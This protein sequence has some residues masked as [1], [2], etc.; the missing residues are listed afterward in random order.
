MSDILI[1]T[2]VCFGAPLLLCLLASGGWRSPRSSLLALA[3]YVVVTINIVVVGLAPSLAPPNPITAGLEWNW[4]GKAAAILASAAMFLL[5]PRGLKAE[6]GVTAAPRPPEWKSVFAVSSGLL[7]FFWSVALLQR[8]G[9]GWAGMAETVVFQGT[10]PGLDEELALRGVTLALLVGAFGKPWRVAGVS[11]GWGAL[12]L[13][14]FFGLVHGYTSIETGLNW[15]TI[16][17]TGVAGSGLLWL[18]ERT[19]SIW[20]PVIVHNLMN[21]GS[22]L[23]SHYQ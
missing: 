10:M 7:A 3:A 2:A 6:S 13:V 12:P 11:I 22:L 21:V 18:K 23:I 17:V 16:T 4:I 15:L 1:L 20:V 9:G 5:L 14:A 19:G 8:S